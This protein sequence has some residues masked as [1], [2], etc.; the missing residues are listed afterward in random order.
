MASVYFGLQYLL[1]WIVAF[2]LGIVLAILVYLTW[3][4]YPRSRKGEALKGEPV[5]RGYEVQ[6]FQE[7]LA[8]PVFPWVVALIAIVLLSILV[9]YVVIGLLGGPIG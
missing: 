5:P 8:S 9:Y 7:L 1:F 2:S 3:G 6:T 4:L